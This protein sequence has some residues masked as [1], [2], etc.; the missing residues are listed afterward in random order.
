MLLQYCGTSVLKGV[1][2]GSQDCYMQSAVDVGT[3]DVQ[4]RSLASIGLCG[5]V[6]R[7]IVWREV[8]ANFFQDRRQGQ[9][10][11]S[12]AGAHSMQS[13]CWMER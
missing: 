5:D 7:C 3:G 11:N 10:N 12:N 4:G 1:I 2:G 13:S 8:Y 6:R 9:Y